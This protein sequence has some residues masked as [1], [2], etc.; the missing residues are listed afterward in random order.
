MR[1]RSGGGAVLLVPGEVLWVDVI[2]PAGDPL[3]VDDVG[4]ASHWLGRGVGGRAGRAAGSTGATVHRGPLVRNDVVGARVL[5][6]ARARV[7]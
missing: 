6:R 1:R 5:R 2:L 7:R 4:R 3:W